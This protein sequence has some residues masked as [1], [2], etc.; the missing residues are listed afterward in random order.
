MIDKTDMEVRAIRD[1]RRFFADALTELG[2][3]APFH[4]RTA[5]EI[6]RI[7]EAT[8]TGYIESMQR[9]TATPERTGAALDDTIPF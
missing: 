4:D 1:A 9:Q 2:L 5:E 3:M 7:I 8:V 6:D